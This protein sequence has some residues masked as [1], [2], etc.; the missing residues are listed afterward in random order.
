MATIGDDL[1]QKGNLGGPDLFLAPIGRLPEP[2]VSSYHCNVCEKDYDGC[3]KIDYESPNETVADNLVLV[4]RGQY[5]C[6]TC[7]SPIAEYRVFRKPE[8][9]MDVG[10]AKTAS[11]IAP[12]RDLVPPPPP[13][14]E[15][16]PIPGL[17]QPKSDAPVSI[18]AI[19]GMDVYDERAFK[20]GVAREVGVDPASGSLVLTVESDDGQ[21]ASVTWNRVEKVGEI[22]ILGGSSSGTSAPGPQ[23]GACASCGFANKPDSK[24]CEECGKQL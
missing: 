24:F 21:V 17:T 8:D 19:A 18:S 6:T 16:P 1:Q 2:S 3:P 5:T 4:E 9:G 10:L 20:I 23:Q 12:P 22:I 11:E 15:L 14:E 7:D 13:V